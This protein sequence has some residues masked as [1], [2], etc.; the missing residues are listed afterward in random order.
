MTT[1]TTLCLQIIVIARCFTWPDIVLSIVDSRFAS[2]VRPNES[3][4]TG[5]L[6]WLLSALDCGS[7]SVGSLSLVREVARSCISTSWLLSAA[8]VDRTNKFRLKDSNPS[9]PLIAVVGTDVLWCR[10]SAAKSRFC[11]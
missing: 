9:R 1:E 10:S 6:C 2:V 11:E 7:W 4:A 3:V 5:G 8:A